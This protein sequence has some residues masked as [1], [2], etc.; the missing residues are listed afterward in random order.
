[1][2]TRVIREVYWSPSLP[3]CPSINICFSGGIFDDA[4][5]LPFKTDHAVAVVGFNDYENYWIIR[6]SW[7]EDWGEAGYMRMVMGMNMCGVG[8]YGSYPIIKPF[9]WLLCWEMKYRY[10]KL[11]IFVDVLNPV[12]T[13]YFIVYF[14]TC[15]FASIAS[16]FICKFDLT[17]S[18]FASPHRRLFPFIPASR[19]IQC[20]FLI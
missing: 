8:N 14:S 18:I 20:I 17:T 11:R 10:W 3:Q 5:C 13:S 4:G 12:F 1:M 6:N 16:G 7:A 9:K 15:V 19:N 2:W